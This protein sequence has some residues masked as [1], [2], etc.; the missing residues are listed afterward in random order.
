[1]GEMA[2]SAVLVALGVGI[3]MIVQR[4][5]QPAYPPPPHYLQPPPD[6]TSSQ[7]G[8]PR[9]QQRSGGGSTRGGSARGE[10]SPDDRRSDDVPDVEVEGPSRQGTQ[11]DDSDPHSPLVPRGGSRDD[12]LSHS[13]VHNTSMSTTA[14]G[15]VTRSH[16]SSARHGGGGGGGPSTGSFRA[17]STL[18]SSVRASHHAHGGGDLRGDVSNASFNEHAHEDTFYGDRDIDELENMIERSNRIREMK[19][20]L[21]RRVG[22]LRGAPPDVCDFLVDNMQHD[23]LQAG[24]TFCFEGDYGDTMFIL[25]FGK[26]EVRA[27][28]KLVG[29]IRDGD[30]FGEAAA[31]QGCLRVAT[32]RAV[33]RTNY[34]T[35]SRDVLME[36][37]AMWPQLKQDF[38]KLLLQRK[39]ERQYSLE[40]RR[41]PDVQRKIRD[42]VKAE[43]EMLAAQSRKGIKWKKSRRIGGGAYGEVYSAIDVRT[44]EP[45]AV[46]TLQIGEMS[47][48]MLVSLERESEIMERLHHRNLVR[49]YGMQRD[50]DSGRIHIIMELVPLGSL[51][52]LIKEFGPVCEAAARTYTAQML[53]GLKYLH[54]EGILHRDI[55]PANAL[56]GADGSIKLADFGISRLGLSH[57]TQTI[58]GTPAYLSPDAINGR[59]SVASDLW[60]LGCSV[61]ELITGEL[62]W[63]HLGLESST[64][65]IFAIATNP[66]P[67]PLPDTISPQLQDL[68][69]VMLAV[70]PDRRG[71]CETLL[72]HEWFTVPEEELPSTGFSGDGTGSG[73]GG[74]GGNT[75]AAGTAQ[76]TSF[77]VQLQQREAGAND[78]PPPSTI[79][80]EPSRNTYDG[81]GAAHADDDEGDG[82]EVI[83][84][85]AFQ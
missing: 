16:R 55:K 82:D 6:P 39:A 48:A 11:H 57:Q 78:A 8:S 7:R 40:E 34:F 56:I 1:M 65:I 74:S 66:D 5:M 50:A 37:I 76:L 19:L 80:T 23:T 29:I 30:F 77:L 64:Q 43:M 59:Y 45:L 33:S 85:D 41:K 58:S 38:E 53:E 83:D 67:Y 51:A 54:S 20:K 69:R 12:D 22:P 25:A 61:L 24:E 14:T 63:A 73:G 52:K 21:I 49:G 68:L 31:L 47:D 27:G 79:G 60:A 42:E 46:K 75:M 4:L 81:D 9:H 3:A 84:Q 17:N 36:C 62:P 18:N 13:L 44:G 70:D 2:K 15:G 26:A 35:I 32:V 10:S 71:D 72:Q 28:R